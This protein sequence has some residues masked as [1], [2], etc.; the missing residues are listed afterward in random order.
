MLVLT[1]KPGDSIILD[2]PSIDPNTISVME[3]ARI[4]IDAED[5]VKIVREELLIDSTI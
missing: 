3:N 5:C 4:G 2:V 1:R